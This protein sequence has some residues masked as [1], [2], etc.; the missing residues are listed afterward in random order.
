MDNLYEVVRE[1]FPEVTGR[2]DDEHIRL[3]DEIDPEMDAL[4]FE[5][6]ANAL[7]L[8]MKTWAP[9]EQ[10]QDLLNFFSAQYRDGSAETKR[11]IDVSFVENLFW[12]VPAERVVPY[13][14]IMPSNL[15]ALYIN[16]HGHN[17]LP[18]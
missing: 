2:A 13:W 1:K 11:S 16:F 8:E 17:P 5:S 14:N 10:Y 4:W 6:L 15:Q 7:N 18:L 9:A 12:Q 3:Y